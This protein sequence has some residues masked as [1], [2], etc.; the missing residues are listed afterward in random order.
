MHSM[1]GMIQVLQPLLR[2]SSRVGCKQR[3]LLG[4]G[5]N[6]APGAVHGHHGA[7][8]QAA[9][10]VGGT[11]D[12]WLIQGQAHGGVWLSALASSL[13]TAAA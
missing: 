1:G 3:A 8:R 4:Q 5:L 13:M 11:D 7:V 12:D 10:G 9:G 6:H 2:L